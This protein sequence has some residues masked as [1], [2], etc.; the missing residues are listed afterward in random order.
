[1][2]VLVIL[3]LLLFV[4]IKF[5]MVGIRFIKFFDNKKNFKVLYVFSL[6][7]NLFLVGELVDLWNNIWFFFDYC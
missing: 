5:L 2:L 7:K 4:D 1:M 6:C 3:V